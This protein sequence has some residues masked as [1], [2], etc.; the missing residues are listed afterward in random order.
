MVKQFLG[1]Q[2]FFPSL[3]ITSIDCSLESNSSLRESN[4]PIASHSIHV[5]WDPI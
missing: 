1:K 5:G 4:S 2:D 3:K